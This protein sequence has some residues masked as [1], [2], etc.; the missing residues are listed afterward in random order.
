MSIRSFWQSIK[1][2]VFSTRWL[3]QLDLL[4]KTVLLIGLGFW[5][6]LVVALVL[7]IGFFVGVWAALWIG[8]IAEDVKLGFISVAAFF[9]CL[10]LCVWVWRKRIRN[11]LTNQAIRALQIS[12]PHENPANPSAASGDEA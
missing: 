12:I 9:F 2:L 6:L 8:A 5:W 4:E 10:L 1:G 7:G 3:I 11:M